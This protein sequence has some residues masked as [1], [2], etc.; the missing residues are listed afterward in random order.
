[1][2]PYEVEQIYKAAVALNTAYYNRNNYI[3]DELHRSYAEISES[4]KAEMADAKKPKHRYGKMRSATRDTY[5]PIQYLESLAGWNPDSV[6]YKTLS[7]G[8]ETGERKM[9]RYQEEANQLLDK[10]IEENSEW[11]K[12]ADGQGKDGIWYDVKIPQLIELKMGGK[13]VFEIGRA[14][15]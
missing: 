3:G 6:W 10:F 9:R 4:V 8:L 5:N 13:A 2:T 11:M 12:K 1:M 14:H 7:K 15:V